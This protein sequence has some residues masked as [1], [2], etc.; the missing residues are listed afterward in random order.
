M[1]PSILNNNLLKWVILRSS[2]HR[3]GAGGV[4]EL[5]QSYTI[6]KWQRQHPNQAH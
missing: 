1:F 6:S 4:K 5:V 2:F 3:L